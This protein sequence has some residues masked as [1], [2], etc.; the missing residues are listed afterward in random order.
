MPPK[1]KTFPKRTSDRFL[2]LIGSGRFC[3]SSTDRSCAVNSNLSFFK[4]MHFSYWGSLLAAFKIGLSLFLFLATC[5][6]KS[7][8]TYMFFIDLRLFHIKDLSLNDSNLAIIETYLSVGLLFNDNDNDN[9]IILFEH[10][11]NSK[12]LNIVDIC[13]M[14]IMLVINIRVCPGDLISAL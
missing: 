10:K 5:K 13:I 8:D 14:L 1:I 2:G 4:D 3:R 9:E 7:S 6:G 12:I 11:K